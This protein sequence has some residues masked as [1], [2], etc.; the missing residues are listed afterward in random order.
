[1]NVGDT[2]VS[3]DAGGTSFITKWNTELDRPGIWDS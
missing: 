3:V 2:S 1:M